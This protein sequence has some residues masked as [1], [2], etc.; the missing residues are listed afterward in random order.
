MHLCHGTRCRLR[1]IVAVHSTKHLF[2]GPSA[3]VAAERFL[4]RSRPC[5]SEM[6]CL[7]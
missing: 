7:F 2:C 4:Q 3:G 6:Q 1:T 5:P